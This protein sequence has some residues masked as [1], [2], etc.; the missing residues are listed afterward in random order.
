MPT[1]GFVSLVGAG[2]GD[3]GL[4][5]L[6]AQKRLQEADLVVYDYLA[7]PHHLIHVSKNARIIGVGKGYRHKKLSQDKINSLILKHARAGR[8]VVRLKGGDPFLFGRGGEEALFLKKHGVSF[9]VVPGITSAV[10]CAAY[11]GIPMTHRAHN[12]SVTFITGHRANDRALDSIDW[13]K[14]V[15]LDGTIAIYMGLYNLAHITRHLMEAGLAA[16]TPVAV[17]EWGTLPRQRSCSG[18][19]DQIADKV[20]RKKLEAPAMIIVGDVVEL[21]KDLG[22]YEKLPLF[23]QKI[24]VLRM[25]DKASDLSARFEAHGAEVFSLPVIEIQNIHSFTKL[26]HAIARI[27]DFDWLVFTSSYGVESFMRRLNQKKKDARALSGLKIAAAGA[28]TTRKLETYG[29]SADLVSNNNQAGSLAHA[30]GKYIQKT[31][32]K[33]LLLARTDIAPPEMEKILRSYGAQ[34]TPLTAYRTV[35]PK[36]ST[37]ERKLAVHFG[38]QWLAFTSSSSAV[39]FVKI[40]G[41]SSAM[42]MARSSRVASIGPSTSRT[43]RSLGLPV[44]AEAI[45]TDLDGLVK[46]VIR[47]VK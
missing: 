44:K 14:I 27:R 18:R 10:A 6:K 11:A 19:L 20:E 35:C 33:K 29:L 46:A 15:S 31:G 41:K 22:W 23:G 9:E 17:I 47:K 12:T 37:E 8:Q 39:N 1:Q 36:I 3:P 45:T 24:M 28:E 13:K 40:F 43:L 32:S 34:V 26:D 4:L 30:L 21:S 7:N 16:R 25:K 5:T 2:P 42:R 38:A